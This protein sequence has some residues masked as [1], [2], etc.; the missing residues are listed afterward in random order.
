MDQGFDVDA[1]GRVGLR[2][3]ADGSQWF[4]EVHPGT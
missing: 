2:L 3:I 1:D 4:V